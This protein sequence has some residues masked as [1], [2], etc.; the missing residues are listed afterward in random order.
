LLRIV[1]TFLNLTQTTIEV[2]LGIKH[3]LG[4]ADKNGW[5]GELAMTEI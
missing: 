2:S 1:S 4:D 3:R 5:R